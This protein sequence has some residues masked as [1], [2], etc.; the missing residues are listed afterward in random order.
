M[1]VAKS[2]LRTGLKGLIYALNI[3]LIAGNSCGLRLGG[4][5]KQ[6]ARILNRRM[7]EE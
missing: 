2:R 5:E 4:I 7:G 1:L 3:V 6:E